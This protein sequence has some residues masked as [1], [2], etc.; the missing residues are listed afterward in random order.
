MWKDTANQV[1]A[2]LEG[3][4][5]KLPPEDARSHAILKQMKIDEAR[6]AQMA[7]NSGA[8]DLPQP[9]RDLMRL[10]AGA[11]KAVAYRI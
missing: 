8:Y 6:H 11:M 7:E 4:I 1:E 2:H 10:T 5:E 3:H 9:V